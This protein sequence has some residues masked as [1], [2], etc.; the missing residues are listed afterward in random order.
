MDTETRLN[1]FVNNK[2]LYRNRGARNLALL[3][4]KIHEERQEDIQEP[5]PV[6]NDVEQLNPND[7]EVEEYDVSGENSEELIEIVEPPLNE[8]V[9]VPKMDD[10]DMEIPESDDVSFCPSILEQSDCVSVNDRSDMGELVKVGSYNYS[11]IACKEC[12][13]ARVKFAN[14]NPDNKKDT[15]NYFELFCNKCQKRK[16]NDYKTI[17]RQ[18][19]EQSKIDTINNNIKSNESMDKNK[20][21]ELEELKNVRANSNVSTVQ[22]KKDL[23]KVIGKNSNLNLNL[24]V[25]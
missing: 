21:S 5:Q 23:K 16:Y 24:Y 14:N 4:C 15:F 20:V 12:D 2:R 18:L 13:K 3:L 6:V 11:T 1:E 9:E 7:A 17:R 22:F 19:K 25:R 10:I 8:V